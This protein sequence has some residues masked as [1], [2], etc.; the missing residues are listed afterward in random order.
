MPLEELVKCFS[1][2]RMWPLGVWFLEQL[3]HLAKERLSFPQT[4][5]A[6]TMH[7]AWLQ[8]W[9]NVGPPQASFPKTGS[10]PHISMWGYSWEIPFKEMLEGWCYWSNDVFTQISIEALIPS[11]SESDDIGDKAF[12][13]VI[14]FK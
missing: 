14:T 5:S 6:P 10:N 11:T 12:T 2:G 8:N 13:E 9:A 4:N 3:V 1:S 7:T